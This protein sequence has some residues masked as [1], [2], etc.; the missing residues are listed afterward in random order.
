MD[1][2][3]NDKFDP[4]SAKYAG[5]DEVVIKSLKREI[6]NILSSYVGWFDSFCEMIQNALDSVEE[7]EVGE[8]NYNPQISVVVDLM[9]N[10][11]SVS[12]NGIGFDEN[13]Y[14]KFLAPN[15]SFKSGNTRGYKGVGSTFLAYGFNYIQ[16]STKN[17]SFKARGVMRNAKKWLDDENPAGNPQVVPDS[18]ET[19]DDKY[20]DFDKGVSIS[21]RFDEDSYPKDL[22]WIKTEDAESWLKLLRIKTGIGAIIVSSEVD[23]DIKVISKNGKVTETLNNKLGYLNIGSLVSKSRTYTQIIEKFDALYKKKG[24]E[25]RIPSSFK[26]LD[27]VYDTWEYT[28]LITEIT[29]ND[30]EANLIEKYKPT[31]YLCY[32]YSVQI[33]KKINELMNLRSGLN[34]MKGGL[35][36]AANN[37]PQ[38]ELI[39]IPLTRNIGR[40][41]Q[42]HIVI[43]FE[44]CQ[45]DMGRK[46]FQKEIT[47]LGKVIS[48]K[49]LDGPLAKIKKCYRRNTGSS[50]DL[51]REHKV[52]EWKGIMLKHEEDNPLQLIS[53]HFFIPTK[54]ISISSIPSR[55]QDVIA[56]FNQLIAG[57]VIRGLRIMSTNERFIYDGLYKVILEKPKGNHIYD[58]DEN[59]L[60]VDEESVDNII[61]SYHDGFISQPKVLEYKYSLDGLIEDLENG[62]KNSND[63]SLV[64]AWKPDELYKK[65]FYI[66]SLLIEENISLRQYHG[67]T[68]RLFDLSNNELVADM[69]L[70]E[71][72]ILYLNNKDECEELQKKYD[73]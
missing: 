55:E 39:Q 20:N 51:V 7:R 65:S 50:P 19:I 6:K 26:N 22:S 53:D 14:R 46:G 12:D 67:V 13:Q 1:T 43:H 17:D 31:V 25:Y 18:N 49:I 70:L 66:E 60:G 45:V 28:K 29:L 9:S 59:P 57:G 4:L 8:D 40:Q 15:F 2:K 23:I 21:I 68:H 61:D 69:I 35:Q 27:A 64:I 5:N 11:V 41:N 32:V 30:V 33:W 3:Y 54:K 47:D 34:I 24:S 48:R 73:E 71:D 52:D 72:L 10:T 36:L 42:A 38:G 56:L 63:I 58:E 16:I 44:N 37:M 62:T